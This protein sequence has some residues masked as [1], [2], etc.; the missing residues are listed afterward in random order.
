MQNRINGIAYGWFGC[1]FIKFK[2]KMESFAN[3]NNSL[4]RIYAK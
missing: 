2:A 3:I 1:G 4:D